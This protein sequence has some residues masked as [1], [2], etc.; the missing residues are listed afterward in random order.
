MSDRKEVAGSMPEPTV[1]HST[2]VIE[3]EFKA[4]PARV[5]AAWADP[6]AHRSWNV[7]GK[8]WV[9]ARYESDF[10]SAAAK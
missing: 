8:D 3:R 7:P 1:K 6:E 10:R 5:F 2:I 9:L 4:S